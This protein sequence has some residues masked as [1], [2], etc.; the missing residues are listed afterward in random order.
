MHMYNVHVRRFHRRCTD[1]RSSVCDRQR[2]CLVEGLKLLEVGS[3]VLPEQQRVELHI[4]AQNHGVAIY[5]TVV[6]LLL[7]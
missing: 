2:A 1:M 3:L 5:L 4:P 6:M 7:W